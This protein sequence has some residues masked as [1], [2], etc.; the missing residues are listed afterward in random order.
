MEDWPPDPPAKVGEGRPASLAKV[1]VRTLSIPPVE[2]DIKKPVLFY[3]EPAVFFSKEEVA[4]SK[5]A[6]HSALVGKC[7]FGRPS[8]FEI[9]SFLKREFFLQG[10]VII[11]TLDSRHVLLR[12]MNHMDFVKVWLKESLHIKGYLFR[13]MKWTSDFTSGWESLY[14]PVWISFPGLRINFYQGNYLLSIAETID[15]PLQVDGATA[16]C[17][18]T[19]AAHFCVELDLRNPIPSKIWIGCG[20]DGFFQKVVV[21][22]LPSYC[23]SC[24]KIGHA[25]VNCRKAMKET[26]AR[27][28]ARKGKMIVIDAGAQ[29]EWMENQVESLHGRKVS[30]P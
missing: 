20:G 6:F 7:V 22:C 17:I 18:R 10:D 12:F 5:V 11:S 24:F 3:G 30:V 27:D 1:V 9:K 4:R 28:A 15:K 26:L 29:G 8:L 16:N 19:V 21:E 23:V 2:V 13:F 14:A 25:M